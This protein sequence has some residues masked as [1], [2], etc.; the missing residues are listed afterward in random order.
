MLLLSGS[1][2]A[3]S[4]PALRAFYYGGYLV[5]PPRPKMPTQWQE[6]PSLTG[7][8]ALEPYYEQTF[9]FQVDAPISKRWKFTGGLALIKDFAF[10]NLPC[11]EGSV[12]ILGYPY[13]VDMTDPNMIVGDRLMLEVPIG[14]QYQIFEKEKWQMTAAA[15][16]TPQVQLRHQSRYVLSGEDAPVTRAGTIWGG[17][18]RVATGFFR[19]IST[20]LSLG[21]EPTLNVRALRSGEGRIGAG[22]MLS[23]RYNFGGNAAVDLDN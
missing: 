21:L 22:G 5:V 14:L 8:A 18:L 17:G 16:L 9:G 19:E 10:F 6:N 13:Y 4:G 20:H 12:C 11:P 1:A 23:L 2:F 7:Q 3:Q 15:M